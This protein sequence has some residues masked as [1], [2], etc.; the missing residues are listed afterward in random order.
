MVGDGGGSDG[1]ERIHQGTEGARAASARPTASEL[2]GAVQGATSIAGALRA[3]G[4][5]PY[6]R[7]LRSRLRHRVEED[8]LDT[9]HF[10]GQA[11]QRG[12]PGTAPFRRASDILIQH[13]GRRRTR[14][15]L[16]R[17]ALLEVG[18]PERWAGCEIGPEWLGRPMTLEVDHVDGDWSDDRRENLR[19]LCP[20]CHA[21]TSTW[22]R[23]GRRQRR[24]WNGRRATAVGPLPWLGRRPLLNG[25]SRGFRC[26]GAFAHVGSTPIGRTRQG[27]PVQAAPFSCP[28]S[29]AVPVAPAR[30]RGTPCLGG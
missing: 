6:K 8:N 16:L 7:T 1:R 25:I 12:G 24:S 10:L 23:G 21:L 2:R 15:H 19:L 20:N 14:S 3:L 27:P 17:R 5:E 26:L 30:A 29:P 22:C 13:D 11:H 4:M 28:L 18:E 9:S